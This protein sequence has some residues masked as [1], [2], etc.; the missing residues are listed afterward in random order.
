ARVVK[1]D[2]LALGKG[3]FVCDSEEETLSALKEIFDEKRFGASGNQVVLERKLVGEEISLLAFCD[4]K[5]LLPMPPCQDHKRRFYGDTG[6]NTGGMGAYSPVTLYERCQN[7]IAEQVLAPLEAALQSGK[8]SYKG[9]LYI[10]LL[11][12]SSDSHN[13]GTREYS[14]YVLEFNARF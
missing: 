5:K 6:P 1:V 12:V 2:G 13:G 8:L 9:L 7:E 11:V 14:P 10:G 3:V 4:G